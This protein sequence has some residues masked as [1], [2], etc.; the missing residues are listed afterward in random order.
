M[1]R[2][3]KVKSTEVLVNEDYK[4]VYCFVPKGGC[5]FWIR[6]FRFLS[7]DVL[8]SSEVKSLLDIDRFFAHYSPN[9]AIVKIGAAMAEVENESLT[10][11]FT[12]DPYRRLWSAYIDKIFLPDFWRNHGY[13]I[14]EDRK[15]KALPRKR[16]STS[17]NKR[18]S[19]NSSTNCPSDISV[20]TI[21]T[22]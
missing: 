1:N 5:T 11:I 21:N 12:R 15:K 17:R 16:P 13:A 4:L 9:D 20:S 7:G 19:T 2:S 8:N 10:F 14:L 22:S 3:S 6:L 18:L